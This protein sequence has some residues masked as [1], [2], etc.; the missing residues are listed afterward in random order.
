MFETYQNSANIRVAR[1]GKVSKTPRKRESEIQTATADT[2]SLFRRGA[3]WCFNTESP[4]RYGTDL[5]R[6]TT[7]I[8]DAQLQ[9]TQFKS[10]LRFFR[11]RKI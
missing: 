7:R 9:P 10:K 5:L 1:L 6:G 4:R 11:W 3:S 8:S 2:V